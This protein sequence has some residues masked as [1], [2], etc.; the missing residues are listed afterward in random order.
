MT[1]EETN[2]QN[3]VSEEEARGKGT[4]LEQYGGPR[5]IIT[6]SVLVYFF[7]LGFAN[8]I[9]TMMGKIPVPIDS[10]VIWLVGITVVVYFMVRTQEKATIAA[11][12]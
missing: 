12:K 9:L 7:V 2:S 10:T 11:V 4:K 5:F 8:I 3:C 6:C 1:E